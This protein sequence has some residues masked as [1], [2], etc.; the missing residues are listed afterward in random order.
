MVL[1]VRG[2]APSTFDR[3]DLEPNSIWPHLRFRK[4][5]LLVAGANSTSWTGTTDEPSLSG[6]IRKPPVRARPPPIKKRSFAMKTRMRRV[7]TLAAALTLASL[8]GGA[9]FAATMSDATPHASI[10]VFNQKAKGDDSVP[11][12]YACKSRSNNPSQ[13]RLIC[14]AAPD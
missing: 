8:G 2:G 5:L 1:F 14:S 11:I 9:A 4:L 7:R 13:K 12:K 6:L 10:I 3:V